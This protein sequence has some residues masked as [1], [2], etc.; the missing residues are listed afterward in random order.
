MV[1]LRLADKKTFPEFTPPSVTSSASSTPCT[2]ASSATISL[3]TKTSTSTIQ[4]ASHGVTKKKK[5]LR[6]ELTNT[7]NWSRRM[8]VPFW[9]G[10]AQK[11]D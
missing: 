4:N 3:K 11:L 1:S 7:R 9:K 5:R 10:K 2:N 8:R 6:S